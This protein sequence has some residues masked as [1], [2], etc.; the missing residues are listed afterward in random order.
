MSEL[1]PGIKHER[2]Y[3]LVDPVPLIIENGNSFG[4]SI[5]VPLP[6]MKCN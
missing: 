1:L 6:T 4:L 2:D 3:V 5:T